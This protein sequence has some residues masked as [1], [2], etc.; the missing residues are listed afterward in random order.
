MSP[1]S[2]IEERIAERAHVRDWAVIEAPRV[3]D[4]ARAIAHGRPDLVAEFCEGQVQMLV[5]P[6]EEI[7]KGCAIEFA[8]SVH[9]VRDVFMLVLRDNLVAR[10]GLGD[11]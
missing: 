4:Q 11:A 8:V 7:V 2:D 5:C 6:Y 9:A 1:L 10:L 3:L